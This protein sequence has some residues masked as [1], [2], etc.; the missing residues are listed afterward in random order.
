MTFPTDKNPIKVF[1]FGKVLGEIYR[2]MIIDFSF[3]FLTKRWENKNE[4]VS[5]GAAKAKAG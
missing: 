3:R 1:F 5:C 2:F 4:A